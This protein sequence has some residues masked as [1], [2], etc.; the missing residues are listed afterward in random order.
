MGGTPELVRFSRNVGFLRVCVLCWAAFPLMFYSLLHEVYLCEWEVW[1]KILVN[2]STRVLWKV[3]STRLPK[4]ISGLC[5]YVF[6]ITLNAD[7]ITFQ[8][9]ISQYWM[10]SILLSQKIEWIFLSDVVKWELGDEQI[11]LKNLWN[12]G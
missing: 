11:Y 4:I 9:R 8:P 1:A 7:A 5:V 10:T 6:F 12:K 2:N 3:L